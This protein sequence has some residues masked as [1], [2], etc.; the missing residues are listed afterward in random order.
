MSDKMRV[1]ILAKDLGVQSKVIIGKCKAEGLKVTNHMSTLSVGLEA[2]IREWFSEGQ[3]NTAVETATRVDLKKARVR[4]KKAPPS[5]VSEAQADVKSGAAAR[6]E[7]DV[8]VAV[9]GS[10]KSPAQAAT[11]SESASSVAAVAEAP[12]EATLPGAPE[13]FDGGATLKAPGTVGVDTPVVVPSDVVAVGEQ[14]ASGLPSTEEAEVAAP[15]EP[16]V[17]AA[18]PSEPIGPA[19]LPLPP[20][21]VVPAGPQ[22]VPQPA[23]LKGPRVVRYEAPEESIR[24]VRPLRRRPEGSTPTAAAPVVPGA[25]APDVATRRRVRG[26]GATAEPAK[27]RGSH[28][29]SPG[30]VATEKL[31][32]W[33]DR[34][35]VERQERISGATGRRI[36]SHRVAE[37]A[38][39]PGFHGPAAPKTEAEIQEPIMMKDLCSTIGVSMIQ[40]LPILKREFSVGG[41]INMELTSDMAELVALEHGINLTVK[42][43]RTALDEIQQEF[44]ERELLQVKSRPPVV[45][46]LGHVD[47]GKTSLLD[48]IRASHVAAKEDGGITQHIGAYH[49]KHKTGG[50]VT[51]LDTPGHAAF[52]AMRARGAKITDIVVLVV[53]ADDGVMPQTIEAINHAKVAAVPVVV[54]LNKIDLG[55]QNVNKIYGQLAAEDLT[56]GG[57]WGGETDVIHTSANTGEGID[58]LV[59]HLAALGEVLD[60]KA[61]S[62]GDAMGSVIEAETKEGVGAV[63]RVL[64]QAGN[65]RPGAIV[66]CGN[67]FGKVRALIND[68]GERIKEAG[69][70]IPVEI[71]GLDEVPAAGDSFYQVKSMQRAKTIAEDM[72]RRRIS[73]GRAESRR[74]RSLEEVF[75][76]RDAGGI[77]ELNVILKAD[78]DGSVDALRTMLAGIPSDEVRLTIRHAGVGAV[79]DS[80]VLLAD[81]CNAVVIGFRVIPGTGARRMADEKGVDVRHYKVIYEV[82][83]DIR[84]AMEGLL[85]P[86]EK[87]ENRATCEVRSVFK[88]SKLGPVAGCFVVDGTVNRKHLVRLIRDGVVVR[89]GSN[90]A[91]LRRFK[92]DAKEVRS[93]MECGLRIEGFDDVKT[94]DVIETYEIIKLARTLSIE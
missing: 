22:N 27:G 34:D 36:G 51:F 18:S 78:V 43:A 71:W 9:L 13:A 26:R 20:E 16:S 92:D 6:T 67:A 89:E 81:A 58:E 40:I 88:I 49:L 32:E 93:G 77:P 33:R 82:M 55:T 28:R 68:R 3:H 91:S 29:Y 8:G 94:G 63:V 54:A 41:S 42:P 57:D 56:P 25:A 17:G 10:E 30:D 38:G 73:E 76:R 46:F 31:K 86:D 45:T 83:E 14:R 65:L 23:R 11:D 84:K 39:H 62:K 24:P 4:K 48:V 35:L 69:P 79:A 1:H 90:I 52:T 85:A 74:F 72:R 7:A 60:F 59:E 61:D 21:P 2:T 5:A 64:V 47:H 12:P 75:K 66:V 37:S 19:K 80:D 15:S 50:E 44:S 70:S 53:A 87:L